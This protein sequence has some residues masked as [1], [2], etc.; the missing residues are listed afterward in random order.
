MMNAPISIGDMRLSIVSGGRLWIDGGNMFGVVPRVMWEKKSPPDE[1]HRIQLDTNCILVRTRDS[2]GLVD[3][4]YGSKATTKFRQR[5]SLED[6]A[7]LVRNL[8]AADVKP[9][10][11]DWVILTH[12]HFDHAGGVTYRDGDGRVWPTFSRA[13]HFIQRAEWEDATG[14]LPELAGS[15][16]S[17]DFAPLEQAGLLD[18]IDGNAE[19][20]PGIMT[21]LTGGHTRGHQIVRFASSDDSAVCLADMCPTTAH[22]PTFWT[23]ASG[24][25]ATVGTL[26]G[27][28]FLASRQNALFNFTLSLKASCPEIVDKKV[29]HLEY[30]RRKVTPVQYKDVREFDHSL[31]MYY[32]QRRISRFLCTRL[33]A[34]IAK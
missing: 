17:D 23:K 10:Q 11:I 32:I 24:L 4:G 34:L 1:Q 27:P 26:R 9:D 3:S 8:A 28:S 30:L 18:L 2:L 22:L 14:N 25:T 6:G 5:H 29:A 16:Y 21:Q 15:Y 13:R 33:F 12:L 7:Q 31:P 19:I 20:A